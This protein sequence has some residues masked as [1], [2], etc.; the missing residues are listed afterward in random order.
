MVVRRNYS[1]EF[2]G[3]AVK[4][5]QLPRLHRKSLDNRAPLARI[6]FLRGTAHHGVLSPT[7]TGNQPY[8]SS[9][10][11]PGRRPPQRLLRNRCHNGST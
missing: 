10:M 1:D 4:L 2:R 6:W 11:D 8:P 7:P 9:I 3:E 5:A